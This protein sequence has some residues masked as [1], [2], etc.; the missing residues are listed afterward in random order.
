MRKLSI[1]LLA[2]VLVLSVVAVP[3]YQGAEAQDGE[4]L[5]SV[6]GLN[7]ELDYFSN[8]GF[9]EDFAV[10]DERASD[11]QLLAFPGIEE[12]EDVPI[13]D[14]YVT[15]VSQAQRALAEASEALSIASQRLAVAVTAV[16]QLANFGT[17]LQQADAKARELSDLL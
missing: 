12:E 1:A 17:I 8:Y 16:Q 14:E 9:M 6:Q 13:T 5:K 11:A 2:F 3:S 4:P 10:F 15:L 7:D